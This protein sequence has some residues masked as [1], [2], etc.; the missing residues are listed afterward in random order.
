ME[1]TPNKQWREFE[2]LFSDIK[3]RYD[4]FLFEYG[5][6][7]TRKA[8]E[9]LLGRISRIKGSRD[10]KKRL[11]IAEYRDQAHRVWWAIVAKS[12]PLMSQQ[13][14]AK[15][16]KLQ[17]LPRYRLKEDNPV[18]EI[19]VEYGPWTVDTLPFLP[20]PREAALVAK[21][22]SEADLK[23]VKAQNRIQ[24]A[25][26]Q[27][28][29]DENGLIFQSRDEIYKKLKIIPD[30]VLASLQWEF[31]L[32]H[33]GK[34]HW[35]PTIKW[36]QGVGYAKVDPELIDALTKASFQKHRQKHHLHTTLSESE[37][38]SLEKFQNQIRGE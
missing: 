32:K 33:G 38:K 22:V 8:H 14:D 20:T 13:F 29:M 27:K 26:I 19:L 3:K 5:K 37:L 11:V 35:R 34:P 21:K 7:L 12:V 9:Y 31:G 25:E 15:T 17:V 36:V 28:L 16:T 24:M 23:K 2:K 4:W 6:R 10:Y 30:F 1:I 18:Q